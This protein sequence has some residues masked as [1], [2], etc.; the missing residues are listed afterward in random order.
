[1]SKMFRLPGQTITHSSNK[2]FLVLYG[3]FLPN[4]CILVVWL[5]KYFVFMQCNI[6][7]L[8]LKLDLTLGFPVISLNYIFSPNSTFF[9]FFK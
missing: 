3:L 6:I 7:F 1:M 5:R 2:P 8:L 9:F 4:Y